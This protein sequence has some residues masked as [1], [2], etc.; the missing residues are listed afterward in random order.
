MVVHTFNP[1]TWE[2]EASRFQW[3]QGQLGLQNKFQEHPGL[4]RETL[5]QKKNQTPNQ[6]NQ[7]TK[8][9]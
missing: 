2:G 1:H 7:S 8:N 6:T 3:V 9:K 5:S 4:H